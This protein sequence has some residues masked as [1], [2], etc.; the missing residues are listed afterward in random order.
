MEKLKENLASLADQ[1]MG[2]HRSQQKPVDPAIFIG[3]VIGALIGAGAALV[4]APQSGRRTQDF[5]RHQGVRLQRQVGRTV[6]DLRSDIDD[7]AEDVKT[8]VGEVQQNGLSILA[9]QTSNVQ[10]TLASA[11]NALKP[12]QRTS[13]GSLLTLTVALAAVLAAVNVFKASGGQSPTG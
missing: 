3:P 11:R 4:L 5:L 13:L 2:R 7:A 8:R 1:V 9:S 10:D 6:E 12:V